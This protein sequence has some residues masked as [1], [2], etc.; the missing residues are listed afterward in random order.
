MV[1]GADKAHIHM[2]LRPHIPQ[3]Q[4]HCLLAEDALHALACLHVS[5]L[6]CMFLSH[7][8]SGPCIQCTAIFMAVK[9]VC[10]WSGLCSSG[11]CGVYLRC[12]TSISEAP[13]FGTGRARQLRCCCCLTKQDAPLAFN[14]LVVCA[15][16]CRWFVHQATPDAMPGFIPMLLR[17]ASICC[18]G[19]HAIWPACLYVVAS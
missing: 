15:K 14:A 11:F 8:P 3:Q 9:H 2:Q 18:C 12:C 16:L 10:M 6:T 19:M 4:H 1:T 13:F 5:C 7:V 17:V